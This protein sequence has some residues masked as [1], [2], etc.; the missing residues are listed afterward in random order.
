VIYLDHNATTPLRPA[1]RAAML[2]YFGDEFG[3]PSSVHRL[4]ARARVAIESA[5]ADLAHAIGA[6]PSEVVFTGGGTESNNLALFGV[7]ANREGPI[8]T[9][10]IEHS[11]ILAPLATLATAGR[12]VRRLAV[13]RDGRV[14]LD[15]LDAALRDAPALVSIGWANNE[16]G[17]IQAIPDIAERCRAA[18]VLLHVDAVQAFGK[19]PVAAHA[20]DLMSVSAHK[21][22]GPKGAGALFVRSGVPVTARMFGG[23]QERGLR[24]GTENVAAIVGFGVACN[25]LAIDQAD[26]KRTLRE[27]LWSGLLARIDGIERNSPL[28]PCLP[29]TLNVRVPD[30]RGEA[31]VAALDLEDI[32]AST[33]S[34]CAAGAAEPSHVLR[35]IGLIEDDAR[36]GVRFSL[37]RDTSTADVD[38][39]IQVVDEVVAHMRRVRRQVAHG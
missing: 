23:L 14:D 34:A 1:V 12:D 7:A 22:G 11:S 35:A 32:A 13:D 39:V 3:N 31:L 2:P 8:V 5:R 17:T 30:V 19:I 4:G 15:A 24:A 10:S 33:G 16:I 9:T 20:C 29:N 37:G 18:R 28:D 27:R 36:D 26:Q 25:D 6:R 21:I 38:R